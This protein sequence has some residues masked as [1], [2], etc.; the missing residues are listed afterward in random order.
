MNPTYV[1]ENRKRLFEAT[2]SGIKT[3]IKGGEL[4]A[5]AVQLGEK[6]KIQIGE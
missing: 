4:K 1:A 5:A 6:Y 2:P 3:L